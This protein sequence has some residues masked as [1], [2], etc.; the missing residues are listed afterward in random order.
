MFIDSEVE[1]DFNEGHLIL[2]MQTNYPWD[3]NIAINISVKKTLSCKLNIRIPAWVHKFD[4]SVNG[5]SVDYVLKNGYAF[6]ERNW[7]DGDQINLVLPLKAE[8]IEAHPAVRQAAGK[9]A[10]KRG[11][12]V[13]CIEEVDNDNGIFNVMIPVDSKILVEKQNVAGFELPVL[14]LQAQKRI[15]QPNE[16]LYHPVNTKFENFEAIAIPYFMWANRGKNEMTTWIKRC[17]VS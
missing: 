9:V 16:P 8:V 7:N 13:Y 11:P 4:F 5:N 12:I 2:K 10:L 15:A 17:S 14:K 3:E 1:F 6:I